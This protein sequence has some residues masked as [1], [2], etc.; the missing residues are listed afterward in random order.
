MGVW[1]HATHFVALAVVGA[2]VVLLR[3]QESGRRS[4]FVAAGVLFG[5]A[6]LMKQH[7]VFF[8]PLGAWLAFA[9]GRRR[10][11]RG[12]AAQA[13]LVA[14]GAAIPFA[15]VVAVC[16]A[17][18]VLGRFWFW[19]FTY[20]GRYVTSE[21]AAQAPARL[22]AAFARIAQATLPL[23]IAAGAG[24]VL[25]WTGRR[26]AGVRPVVAGLLAA[27]FL[28]ICP[29]FYFRPHYFIVALPAA[30][31]LVGVAAQG[32]DGAAG[33]LLPARSARIVAAGALVALGAGYV[34]AEREYLFSMSPRELSRA[35]YGANPFV[36]A[37]EIAR[38]IRETTGPGDRVAVLGSEPEVLFYAGRVGA[39]G[40]LYTYPLME[41]QP[42]APQMQDEMIREIESSAPAYVVSVAIESSWLAGPD[43][44]RRIF[45][46]RD[47][48]LAAHYDLVG[49]ADIVSPAESRILWDA[50]ARE[51]SPVSPNVVLT[52]RRRD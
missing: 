34:L 42:L 20:A 39:T 28:A 52:Y 17:Q 51:Y 6:V 46:W 32:L 13:A 1:A 18:G 16:A 38:R 33:R 40:Y 10:G 25:I 27:S 3:A 22:A 30:A 31:L 35:R 44:E 50:E 7:A 11:T 21:S 26:V 43:S 47:R 41:S 24:F 9:D 49:V 2:L 37:P 45:D 19:T 8:V 12:A 14:A 5:V 36:E 4:G 23:W 15:F 48:Y 29:G